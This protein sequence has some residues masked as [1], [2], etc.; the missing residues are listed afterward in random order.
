MMHNERNSREVNGMK[1]CSN[2]GKEILDEAVIC[3]HC[4]C[5]VPESKKINANDAPSFGIA[6]LGFFVPIVGLI[7]YLLWKDETP[8]RAKSAGKGA[9]VSVIVSVALIVLYFVFVVV[10]LGAVFGGFSHY[11]YYY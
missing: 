6:L 5:R 4:G 11:S 7:L 8:M 1:Y 9:L 10:L 2:C 3:V